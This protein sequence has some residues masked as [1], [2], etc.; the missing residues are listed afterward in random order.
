MVAGGGPAGMAGRLA[1]AGDSAGL[2]FPAG[3]HGP[4]SGD[5][6]VSGMSCSVESMRCRRDA[7]STSTT[8]ITPAA[9]ERHLIEI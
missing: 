1:A 9:G 8:D 4:A 2:S 6:G 5:V 7:A 3:L